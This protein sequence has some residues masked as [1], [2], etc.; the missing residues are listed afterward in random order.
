MIRGIRKLPPGHYAICNGRSLDITRYWRTKFNKIE[1]ECRERLSSG[2]EMAVKRQLLSDV[3]L[4]V[5]LSGGMDSAGIV[6]VMKG[7]GVKNI[8]TF[9][10]GF[11]GQDLQNEFPEARR[12]AELFGCE[13]FETVVSAKD[14]QD[15]FPRYV[16]ILEEPILNPSAIAWYFVS[17]LARAHVKVALTGQG[18]DEIFAGYDRYLGEKYHRVAAPILKLGIHR[19]G[20]KLLGKSEKLRRAMNSLGEPDRYRR[21]LDIYAVFT[22]QMKER[23]YKFVRPTAI[24]EDWSHK[25]LVVESNELDSLRQMLY[26]DT[27][28]WLPDDLLTVADKLS[29]AVSLEVRVPY[30][31]VELVEFAEA[32]PSRLKLRGMVQ[33]YILKQSLSKWLPAEIIRRRKKGFINPVAEWLRGSLSTFVNDLVLSPSSACSNYF[34]LEYIRTLMR[35]HKKGVLQN[36]RQILQLLTFELWH[37]AFIK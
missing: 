37:R 22:D 26:L 30:L 34:N 13:H 18:T 28:F 12:T 25:A 36:E 11:E 1:G 14:Y 33:K 31:D 5:F 9:T 8:K 35:E 29:M 6:G 4:G 23:L 27:R 32:I 24:E 3:P 16:S 21:Y 17:K 7:L 10:I 2:I 15:F 19:I 20:G